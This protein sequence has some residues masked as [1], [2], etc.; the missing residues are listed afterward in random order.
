M[1]AICHEK[2]K[3]RKMKKTLFAAASLM[4]FAACSNT[5]DVLQNDKVANEGRLV[6][7]TTTLPGDT[8]DTVWY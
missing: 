3:A 6:T 8:P 4:M 1:A 5:E 7:V 2:L